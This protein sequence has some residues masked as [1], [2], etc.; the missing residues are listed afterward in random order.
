MNRHHLLYPLMMSSFTARHDPIQIYLVRMKDVS[1]FVNDTP[2]D[3]HDFLPP[4]YQRDV[5]LD[6]MKQAFASR[7]GL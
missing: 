2:G 4:H 6:Y 7:N 1:F 3:H 5:S